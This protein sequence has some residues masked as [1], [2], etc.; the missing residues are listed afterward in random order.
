MPISENSETLSRDA[1]LNLSD[2][3]LI[4]LCRV[5]S[6]RAS[7][8]GGQHRNTSDSAVRITLKQS[9]MS[10]YATTSRSQHKNKAEAIKK[11]RILIAMEMRNENSLT[12]TDSFKIGKN[13]KR[14]A[15]FISSILDVF[16]HSEWKIGTTSK[17]LKISTGK[18]N[19]VLNSNPLL[20]ARVNHERLRI[21]LKVLRKSS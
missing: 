4:S 3:E 14:Y 6:F 7:G 12:W 8:P 16:Y 1:L 2:R 20:L 10:T 5:E 19:R 9:R 11:L 17:K 15:A 18:L 13:D 21:G